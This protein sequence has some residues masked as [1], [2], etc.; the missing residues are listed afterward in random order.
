MHQAVIEP[1]LQ[2][3]V[4][5]RK[6]YY[7][8][9]VYSKAPRSNKPYRQPLRLSTSITDT[10]LS[11]DAHHQKFYTLAY[12]SAI[13][14]AAV[15]PPDIVA[16]NIRFPWQVSQT[17]CH[18]DYLIKSTPTNWTQSATA[19]DRQCLA[20]RRQLWEWNEKAV[21]GRL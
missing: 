20:H 19:T 6:I 5:A 10:Y 16:V 18:P 4:I 17:V 7:I 21:P 13:Y 14:H 12:F 8:V 11:A 15:I 3:F 9:L 2:A 1:A